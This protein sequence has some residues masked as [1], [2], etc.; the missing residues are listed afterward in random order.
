M[1]DIAASGGYYIASACNHIVANYGTIT[2]S[3][4]VIALS[5][6]LKNLM[7]KFG[8]KMN[9]IKSGKYKDILA[10]HRDMS[11]E[12]RALLQELIDLSY[13]KFVSDIALGRNMNQSD[14]Y[15]IAD[16]RVMSAQTALKYKLIDQL[17]TFEEAINKAKELAGLDSDAHVYE[18]R[19]SP[20]NEI[21][22]S[23]NSLFTGHFFENR[24]TDTTYKIEYRYMQ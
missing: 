15:P 8:I 6:N 1:G 21:F 5:P 23:I 9:V 4:G 18:E 11:I 10:T 16:G 24:F 3:I 19:L 13:H 20:F 22:S 17:G 7:D 2:G 12:E 14:I